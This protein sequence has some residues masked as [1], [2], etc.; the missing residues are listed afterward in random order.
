MADTADVKDMIS[1]LLMRLAAWIRPTPPSQS[2]RVARQVRRTSKM[3]PK[4]PYGET[5]Q[6]IIQLLRDSNAPM[7]SR[8]IAQRVGISTDAVLWHIRQSP[9]IIAI[10]ETGIPHYTV[11]YTIFE[12]RNG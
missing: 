8:S 3:G 9:D 10:H 4:R 1:N 11:H 12:A 5:R 7:R 2:H 6:M